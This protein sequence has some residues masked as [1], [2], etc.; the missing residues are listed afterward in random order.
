MI[1]NR[2]KQ[3][4]NYLKHKDIIIKDSIT[5]SYFRIFLYKGFLKVLRTVL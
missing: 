3:I 1:P 4:N 2:R 5:V